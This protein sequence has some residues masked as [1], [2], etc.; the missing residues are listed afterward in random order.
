MEMNHFRRNCSTFFYVY[1][2]PSEG[3]LGASP[4]GIVLRLYWI[5]RLTVPELVD[6][7]VGVEEV[8]PPPQPFANVAAASRIN[9]RQAENRTRRTASFLLRNRSGSRRIGR[10]IPA[11]AAPDAVSVKT[12]VI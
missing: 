1:K 4:D 7:C 9:P 6:W 10:K 3:A 2:V 5:V 8:P 11:E 12:T